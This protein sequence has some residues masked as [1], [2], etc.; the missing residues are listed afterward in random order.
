MSNQYDASP[1]RLD[2]L[3]DL[4]EAY[5]VMNADPKPFFKNPDR[6]TH[7][8]SRVYRTLT[9]MR[10]QIRSLHS[11]VQSI[12]ISRAAAGAPSSLSPVDAVRYLTPEQLATAVGGATA[13]TLQEATRAEKTAQILR[14]QA[15][16][17]I[18]EIKLLL[19]PLLDEM[20]IDSTVRSRL[21]TILTH[22][23]QNPAP[24]SPDEATDLD[25][26]FD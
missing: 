16:A 9:A 22:L 14:A 11:S 10:E 6:I 23:D 12:Q 17:S 2:T 15:L 1:S 18:N 19:T 20:R 3:V 5:R 25:A 21:S 24:P 4:D 7:Y 8:A 26:L 13:A